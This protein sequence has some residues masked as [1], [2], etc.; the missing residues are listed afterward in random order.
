MERS[1]NAMNLHWHPGC[2]SCGDCGKALAGTSFVKRNDQPFCRECSQRN[3]VQGAPFIIMSPFIDKQLES[4]MWQNLCGRC[5]KP[6]L[7]GEDILQYLDG[8]FH[9]FHFNCTTCQQ[10]LTKMYKEYERNLYCNECHVAATMP[11]CFGCH[12]PIYGR[13]VT[14]LNR[15]FH[16]EVPI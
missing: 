12:K 8:H 13:S 1:V 6:L 10:P 15:Q 9:A 11:T 16:P 3:K 14:A 4:A 2:F 7:P 5:K